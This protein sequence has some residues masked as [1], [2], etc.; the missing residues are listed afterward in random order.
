MTDPR[1]ETLTRADLADHLVAAGA[2]SR[3]TALALVGDLVDA[4]VQ[5]LRAGAT[6]HLKGLGRFKV[7]AT[8]ERAG[9]NPQTGE[10]CTIPAGRRLK[11][12]PSKTLL[13]EGG[14]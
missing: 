11:F 12:K 5:H 2:I 13:K 8:F 10:A 4:I 3:K 7:V 1:C 6:V 14:A 9:R